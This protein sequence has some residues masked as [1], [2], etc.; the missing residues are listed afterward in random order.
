MRQSR[1]LGRT[2]REVPKDA[3]TAAHALMIRVGYIRQL[4]AGIYVYM[5]LLLRSLNKISQII[6]EEMT[7]A[8][9]EEMLMPAIQNKEL[10]E[11]TGRWER[12]TAIDGI[13]FSFQDRRGS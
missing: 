13:M 12:Y 3:Q 1:H 10:W 2:L 6:R 7:R 4:S 9:S 11:K 5:P 8:G